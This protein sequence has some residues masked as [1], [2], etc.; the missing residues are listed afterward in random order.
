MGETCACHLLRAGGCLFRNLLHSPGM[1]PLT[2]QAAAAWS[3]LQ[4]APAE[5]GVGVRLS[6]ATEERA[7]GLRRH[8]RTPHFQ[9]CLE[10]GVGIR[11]KRPLWG[12]RVSFP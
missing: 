4:G 5:G 11:G 12:Q 8:P 2:P 9:A 10:T 1:W 7:P 3:P 6:G